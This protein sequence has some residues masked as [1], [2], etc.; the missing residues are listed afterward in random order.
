M[1]E[2]VDPSLSAAACAAGS[3]NGPLARPAKALMEPLQVVDDIECV[4][5]SLQLL[6]RESAR[7]CLSR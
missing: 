6:E 4:D 3:V 5:L 7:G 2:L 1:G